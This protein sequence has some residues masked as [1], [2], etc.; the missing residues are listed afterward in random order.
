VCK[1]NVVGN[2]ELSTWKLLEKCYL[3]ENT[4]KYIKCC[5]SILSLN[6]TSIHCAYKDSNVEYAVNMCNLIS[7]TLSLHILIVLSHSMSISSRNAGG[8]I[9]PQSTFIFLQGSPTPPLQ[10][11]QVVIQVFPSTW[12]PF[13][14]PSSSA[15]EIHIVLRRQGCPLSRSEPHHMSQYP[16]DRSVSFGRPYTKLWPQNP[17]WPYVIRTRT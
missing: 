13:T 15:K 10:D 6:Y 5:I 14:F 7:S 12:L 11:R 3:K 4:A 17:V 2:S 1:I 8:L 16:Q 9:C